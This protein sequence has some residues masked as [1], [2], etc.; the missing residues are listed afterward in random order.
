MA[1]INL[2]LWLQTRVFDGL[3][4]GAMNL[5]VKLDVLQILE[6]THVDSL[7]EIAASWTER[8]Y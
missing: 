2:S 8:L 6:N 4:K 3:P 5:S 1:I 7:R